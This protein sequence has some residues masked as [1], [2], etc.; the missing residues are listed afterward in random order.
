MFNSIYKTFLFIY[1][2]EPGAVRLPNESL[3]TTFLTI[4][5]HY[6][7]KLMNNAAKISTSLNI[8]SA[9]GVIVLYSG[10]WNVNIDLFRTLMDSQHEWCNNYHTVTFLCTVPF[11]SYTICHNPGYY[12]YFGT[13]WS[14]IISEQISEYSNSPY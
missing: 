4:I 13:V 7:N 12:M 8:E 11:G 9:F 5:F 3:S 6:N 14:I 10:Q 2:F 1:G